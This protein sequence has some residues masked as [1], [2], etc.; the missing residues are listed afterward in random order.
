MRR[1]GLKLL[2]NFLTVTI[3]LFTDRSSKNAIPLIVCKER[4]EESGLYSHKL[5]RD[6]SVR[7]GVVQKQILLMSKDKNYFNRREIAVKRT[8]VSPIYPRNV[9]FVVCVYNG[10]IST[11]WTL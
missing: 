11:I 7:L 5:E 10:I 3:I 9:V 1:N 8:S 2:P 4:R 6:I